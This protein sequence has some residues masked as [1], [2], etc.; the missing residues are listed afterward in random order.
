VRPSDHLVISES[1]DDVQAALPPDTAVLAYFVGDQQS[2]GWLLTR[3]EL[4]HSV[5]PGRRVLQDL[6]NTFVERQRTGARVTRDLTFSPLLGGLLNDVSAKRL[7][8]LPDGPLN[9]LPFAALPL[10]HGA[11]REML[12]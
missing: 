3:G 12:I 2:H 4:R 6:V 7:L 10:P 5:L 11:T 8:I 9:S 1:R